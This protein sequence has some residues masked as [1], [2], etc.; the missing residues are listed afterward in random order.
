M[1]LRTYTTYSQS[2]P[3]TAFCWDPVPAA[4]VV[5]VLVTDRST[6]AR[7]LI[8]LQELAACGKKEMYLD[9]DVITY[10]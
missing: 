3:L 4:M 7:P 1:H 9:N 2:F 10:S 5:L 6:E 8:V